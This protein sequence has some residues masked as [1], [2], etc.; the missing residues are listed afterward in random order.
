MA[1]RLVGMHSSANDDAQTLAALTSKNYVTLRTL[2]TV[3]G[4]TYRTALRYIKPTVDAE[5]GNEIAP[6]KIKAV[7]VGGTYR[8]YGD[9]LRRFLEQG[10]R[11]K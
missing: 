1:L 3:L 8:I 2:S 5:T 9:E 10:N 4:V 7:R 6:A 11:T